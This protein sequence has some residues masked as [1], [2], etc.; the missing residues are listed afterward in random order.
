MRITTP[1]HRGIGMRASV[2]CGPSSPAPSA[3]PT[4]TRRQVLAAGLQAGLL[5][6]G[7][8]PLAAHGQDREATAA[9]AASAPLGMD[10]LTDAL[11]Q[12]L[13]RQPLVLL[14]EVHDNAVQHAARAQALA[15]HLAA[16]ARPALL[17]EQFDTEQQDAIDAWLSAWRSAQPSAARAR[18]SEAD[19]DA[20]I[21]AVTAAGGTRGVSSGWHWPHY[22]PVLVLALRHDL[23]LHAANVSRARA[24]QVISQGLAAQG[25][26]AAV[27]PPLL[28]AQADA[29]QQG[30]CGLLP[31]DLPPRMALAQVA[32]DQRMA[33]LLAA[34]LETSP[35][36]V[37]LLAGN[38]HVRSDIGV[39][40]WLPA[41]LRSRCL[42]VGLVEEGDDGSMPFDLRLLT[43]RQPRP[44]PCAALQSSP[45]GRPASA[46]R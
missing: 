16:G 38:G 18:A 3:T 42:A 32:R 6:C 33:R 17:M 29:V 28:Q 2:P 12:A 15:A 46:P 14:G 39:P 45:M 4:A 31:P 21:A 20:L 37:L 5:A 23:P 1:V 34:A 22:R 13:R 27:P 25:F 26:D 8:T 41:A 11:T 43:P 10:A 24:R 44:D 30:H 35:Q 19:A 40:A 9:P 7:L 36:G